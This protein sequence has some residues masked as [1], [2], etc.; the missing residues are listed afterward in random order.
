MCLF[1]TKTVLADFCFF[2]FWWIPFW[3]QKGTKKYEKLKTL[4]FPKSMELKLSKDVPT[5]FKTF[6]EQI[7]CLVKFG[8]I[9]PKVPFWSFLVKIDGATWNSKLWS[10]HRKNILRPVSDSLWSILFISNFFFIISCLFVT[11]TVS[12]AYI[13]HLRPQNQ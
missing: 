5:V 6:L 9:S 2:A 7:L 11:K 1:G 3:L 4:N 8:H 13:A 12:K 10:K